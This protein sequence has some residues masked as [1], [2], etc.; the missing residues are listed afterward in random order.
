[1]QDVIRLL[2]DAIANQIAAGEVVQRPASVV[3]E[4]LENS[5]DAQAKNI[6]VIIRDAGR[7]LIQI[8]DDGGGMSE[9]DARMSFERHATSKIRHADDLFK[10]RTMGF[11]GE[12]LASIAAVA[13]IEMRT[14]RPSDE[15]GILLRMEG[16][17][18]KSQESVACLPGTNI[19]VKNLFFNVP[20]RRNFLKTNSVEMRHILDEFQRVALAHPEIS[21]SLYHNDTE[22][23]N[24]YAGKLSRRIVD[25]FGKNYREQLIQCQEETP[26]VTVRG[27]V[28]KPD[29]ARKTRG[30]Q[31]F[32]V[33][34]RY[35]KHSY[36][37]HAVLAAYES[38]ISEGS[39]PF[40]VLMLDIDPSH[41]D[42]N[43]HPTKTEIKF[44]DERSVYALLMAA[45]RKAISINHLSHSID[46]ES[47][48]NF[49][50]PMSGPRTNTAPKPPSFM[51]DS[52]LAPP[53]PT[54]RREE[55]NLSHWEKLFDGF[56]KPDPTPVQTTL[57]LGEKE[58][59]S[60]P[61]PTTLGSRA[62]ALSAE[63]EDIKN[64]RLAV[65][66]QNR[67]VVS[68]VK[69]GMMLIDQRAAYER[70]LYDRYLKQLENQNAAS[71]QL[72][73]PATVRLSPANIPMILEMREE[74]TA[75]GFDFDAL[76]PDTLVVRSL[77][78]DLPSDNIQQLFEELCEQL[79]QSHDEL[80]L[81]RSETT[82]RTLA[83]RFASRYLVRLSSDE[84]EKLINQLFIS[85]NPN[86][87]PSGEPIFVILS[88]DKIAN[89]FKNG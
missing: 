3:K 34:E 23:Y 68:A 7:T 82:A 60:E 45:I 2:P 19:L 5:I 62:N 35:V 31:F 49:L 14:R 44:D 84:I 40:Y 22:V 46:F 37:H 54:S 85:S 4:L 16:S 39:H 76:G 51:R 87:T 15:I 43:I 24:L 26:Y 53:L 9:T 83:R 13:Q 6:Q 52:T 25:M 33:N 11:R 56:Q 29:F 63:D 59:F 71:Q 55:T 50:S 66:I 80:R 74:I 30:E 28:G 10:I 32:F 61:L 73:F 27:F 1:M 17:E 42:I 65:Q 12:A 81:N 36:L 77:P 64:R 75:L 41:I 21:F 18:L 89:L 70:V 78:G 88:L 20:A 48:V 72:L 79:H 86:Y 47:N 58:D 67:Y 8:I 69:S 38:T 57:E